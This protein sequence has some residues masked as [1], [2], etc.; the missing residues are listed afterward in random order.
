[1]AV[2]KG[3]TWFFFLLLAQVCGY[4]SM[5]DNFAL[6]CA[7]NNLGFVAPWGLLANLLSEFHQG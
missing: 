4:K 2:L 5:G 6:F 7:V 1:M 3:N